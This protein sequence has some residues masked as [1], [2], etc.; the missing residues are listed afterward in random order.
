MILGAP[1]LLQVAGQYSR[2]LLLSVLDKM[3]KAHRARRRDVV[4]QLY[5]RV[6]NLYTEFISI[7][8]LHDM[9]IEASQVTLNETGTFNFSPCFFEP[10][11]PGL[12]DRYPIDP[13]EER[14]IPE[15]NDQPSWDRCL[16]HVLA[17]DEGQSV[18]EEKV[19]K[20]ARSRYKREMRCLSPD[21]SYRRSGE[22]QL[23]IDSVISA[24]RSGTEK[25]Y[26]CLEDLSPLGA[27]FRYA[28][29][30]LHY[31]H[32]DEYRCMFFYTRWEI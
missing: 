26:F 5:Q 3:D 15:L 30:L 21:D 9:G 27:Q 18:D 12:F 29:T 24:S 25:R 17:S 28:Q 8:H 31:C 20:Y 19:F 23:Y 4:E 22:T 11:Q 13:T 7:A 1:A 2:E 14:E 10:Q 16:K 32:E 6:E